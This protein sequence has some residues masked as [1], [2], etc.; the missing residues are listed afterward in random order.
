MSAVHSQS[1]SV[2]MTV[3][4]ANVERITASKTSLLSEMCK[5]QHCHCLC[6]QETHR[7]KDPARPR[8]PDMAQVAERPHTKHGSPVF[9]RDGLKVNN[10][11]VCEEEHVQLITV[12]LPGVVVHSIITPPEPF[13]LIIG[14]FNSH[15]TLCGYTTTNNDG[16]YAEQWADSD[17]LS[18]I[19]KAKLPKSF[20]S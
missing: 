5:E 20:N 7:S 18:L 10:L 13:R 4:S 9:I 8:I 12:D 6:L 11:S 14:D 1:P 2:G 17:S 15:S 16:E 3:I 19:H